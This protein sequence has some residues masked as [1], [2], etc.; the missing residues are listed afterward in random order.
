MLCSKQ[1]LLVLYAPV[2]AVVSLARNIYVKALTL[3]GTPTELFQGV[4]SFL[5][6]CPCVQTRWSLGE[7]MLSGSFASSVLTSFS[8]QCSDANPMVSLQI[9][10]QDSHLFK[11]PRLRNDGRAQTCISSSLLSVS[12][13]P[14]P[15]L[16]K[17]E[18]TPEQQ[19][20]RSGHGGDQ[21]GGRAEC[22]CMRSRCWWQQAS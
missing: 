1:Y 19:C 21:R 12:A 16:T 9:R 3:G 4:P 22:G 8:Q 13:H 14:T 18:G 11:V 2:V 20:L 7:L 5:S 10:L 6:P 15:L 17:A